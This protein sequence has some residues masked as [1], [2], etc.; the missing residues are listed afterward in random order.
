MTWS[1]LLIE[2]AESGEDR[3]IILPRTLLSLAVV[4]SLEILVATAD[5]IFEDYDI[6][7]FEMA[8]GVM[9]DALFWRIRD[10][11][12][13]AY[14]LPSRIKRHAVAAQL[15]KQHHNRSRC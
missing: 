10:N 3:T 2:L 15:R 11:R 8:L 12:L 7:F 13:S 4:S 1:S 9:A 6:D 5:I 14:S